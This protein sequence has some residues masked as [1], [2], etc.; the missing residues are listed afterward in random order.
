[1]LGRGDV[2]KVKVPQQKE[3]VLSYVVGGFERGNGIVMGGTFFLFPLRLYYTRRYIP[4]FSLPCQKWEDKS[5]SGVVA[6]AAGASFQ[7]FLEFRGGKRKKRLRCKRERKAYAETCRRNKKGN[8]I[9]QL[10]TKLS[11]DVACLPAPVPDEAGVDLV[12]HAGEARAEA[13]HHGVVLAS[14]KW[15]FRCS[16]L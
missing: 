13:G 5:P 3:D 10:E 15:E 6:D 1:M 9:F 4:S 2:P 8:F 7:S 14:C 11:A 16:R 12:A